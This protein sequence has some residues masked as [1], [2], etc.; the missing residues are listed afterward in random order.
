MDGIYRVD[1][2]SIGN[3]NM[4]PLAELINQIRS[5][6]VYIMGRIWVLQVRR[7]SP[8]ERSL[9]EIIKDNAQEPDSEYFKDKQQLIDVTQEF[10]ELYGSERLIEIL[11]SVFNEEPTSLQY[12]QLL[13]QIPQITLYHHNKL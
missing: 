1:I 11:E 6:N 7:V 12:H 8:M 9:A 4:D 13:T 5:G 2:E 3:N 10:T